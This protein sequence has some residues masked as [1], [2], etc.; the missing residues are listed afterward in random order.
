M[1]DKETCCPG[2]RKKTNRRYRINPAY[3]SVPF[4]SS[5]SVRLMA[6]SLFLPR[7][8]LLRGSR[9]IPER[10]DSIRRGERVSRKHENEP[11]R[12]EIRKGVL[13]RGGAELKRGGISAAR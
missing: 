12:K 6:F 9:S 10:A 4:P 7:Y 11:V 5:S 1:L 2:Q 13:S 3:G 8:S